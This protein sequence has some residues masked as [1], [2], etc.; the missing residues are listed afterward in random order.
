MWEAIY[1]GTWAFVWGLIV[2]GCIMMIV[3]MCGFGIA[4]L[5]EL[6]ARWK[7]QF[8]ASSDG[9]LS[10]SE[11]GATASSSSAWAVR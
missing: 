6:G 5:I 10:A 3:S 8:R 4:W 9:P 11:I 1:G 2:S 7:C